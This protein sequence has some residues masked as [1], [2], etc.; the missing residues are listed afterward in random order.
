MSDFDDTYEDEGVVGAP[1]A[2]SFAGVPSDV[3]VP[4][5][6]DLNALDLYATLAAKANDDNIL[7]PTFKKAS[8]AKQKEIREKQFELLSPLLKGQD[9]HIRAAFSDAFLDKDPVMLDDAAPEVAQ[10]EDRLAR[11]RVGDPTAKQDFETNVITARM[12]KQSFVANVI[13]G[14]YDT[15]AEL[16]DPGKNESSYIAGAEQDKIQSYVIRHGVQEGL[17]TPKDVSKLQGRADF[18]GGAFAFT[19]TALAQVLLVGNIAKGGLFTK[20]AMNTVANR[21]AAMAPGLGRQVVAAVGEQAVQAGINAGLSALDT[22]VK[23]LVQQNDTDASLEGFMRRF[24]SDLATDWTTWA[25]IGAVGGTFKTLKYLLKGMKGSLTGDMFEAA[26]R[27]ADNIGSR[28]AAG[29]EIPPEVMKQFS[30]E[31]QEN[32]A[33]RQ[34]LARNAKASLAGADPTDEQLSLALCAGYASDVDATTGKVR[35]YEMDKLNPEDCIGEFRTPLEA[36]DWAAK[37]P[38]LKTANAP[39]DQA[40]KLAAETEAS[41]KVK[42]EDQ[43]RVPEDAFD[44]YHMGQ[45]LK[46]G[47]DGEYDPNQLKFVGQQLGGAYG[48]RKDWKVQDFDINIDVPGTE[49]V[50]MRLGADLALDQDLRIK[51][52]TYRS[53][54][55]QGA[56]DAKLAEF[57]AAIDSGVIPRFKVETPSQERMYLKMLKTYLPENEEARGA[58]GDAI[59]RVF[60]TAQDTNPLAHA[61]PSSVEHL[62]SMG[63]GDVPVS[64]KSDM[65]TGIKRFELWV[66]Q[67]DN[68]WRKEA[69]FGDLAQARNAAVEGLVNGGRV[70][71][72]A[73]NAGLA[74]ATG[75]QIKRGKDGMFSIVKHAKVGTSTEVID[76]GKS[77][78]EIFQKYP[79]LMTK[80]KLPSECGPSLR[81]IDPAS[82]ILSYEG[83]AVKGNAHAIFQD[84]SQYVDP[85]DKS[86]LKYKT[87]SISTVDG[88]LSRVTTDA[89]LDPISRT[90]KYIPF[91]GAVP[92]EFPTA[93]ALVDHLESG[94]RD[95]DE[96][97]LNAKIRGYSLYNDM[98]GNW[99][100]SDGETRERFSTLQALRDK[101]TSEPM[102][103]APELISDFDDETLKRL[104]GD[105]ARTRVSAETPR[106][107]RISSSPSKFVRLRD[108]MTN[109]LTSTPLMNYFAPARSYIETECDRLGDTT[110]LKIFDDM[111]GAFRVKNKFVHSAVPEVY[112]LWKGT[113]PSERVLMKPMLLMS[114]A[115]RVAYA[116]ENGIKY[117]SRMADTLNSTL[118]YMDTLTAYA[119]LGPTQEILR[120]GNTVNEAVE[121][122]RRLGKP[123]PNDLE[124]LMQASN[125]GPIPSFLHQYK[126]QLSVRSFL[127]D[128]NEDDPAMMLLHMTNR[129]ASLMYMKPLQEGF[130]QKYLSL[131]KAY[132]EGGPKA[133]S[134]SL[135]K[136]MRDTF[137]EM[138]GEKT[139]AGAA[140]NES[141]RK[142]TR[143]LAAKLAK[144][145]FFKDL[146]IDDY[147]KIDDLIGKLGGEFT[148]ASQAGR[149]WAIPRNLMQNMNLAAVTGNTRAFKAFQY[150]LDN[151]A[152]MDKL[153]AR[154]AIE[155]TMYDLG[156]E[157]LSS[158]QR[159]KKILMAP[160]EV[161]DN[162]TRATAIR[163]AEMVIED[164]RPRYLKGIT[165]AEQYIREVNGDLLEEGDKLKFLELSKL[166]TD[167]AADF[168]GMRYQSW[169]MYDYA[170]Y[171]QGTASRGTLGRLWGKLG[172]YP[173]WTL[174]LYRRVLSKGSMVDRISRMTRMATTSMAV[175][176]A[177][178]EAGI[179]YDG[180]LWTNA[181]GFSGGPFFQNSIDVLQMWGDSPEAKM[182]RSRLKSNLSRELWAPAAWGNY[183]KRA[184]SSAEQNNATEFFKAIMAMPTDPET[185]A[186]L[187]GK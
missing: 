139:T 61:N 149:I 12:V 26:S 141:T 8:Y 160:L 83:N 159:A 29:E 128:V 66:K 67:A 158:V 11:M 168:L 52:S 163:S 63:H 118:K 98:K 130:G 125:L 173:L 48:G 101:F 71:L 166:N 23:M 109:W 126:N 15:L 177:F 165:N 59:E 127:E 174:D 178:K 117:T 68:T 22:G 170:K 147:V 46:A 129:A 150:V 135:L 58:L 55:L 161:T 54:A 111:T 133:P 138:C 79:G 156:G 7:D 17:L 120:Y 64:L 80:L 65:A 72:D 142:A 5:G 184:I 112:S 45:F 69:M 153:Q 74:S 70:S 73:I 9:I 90:F 140:L 123:I 41:G 144:Q 51:D 21:A 136:Y 36:S 152:Y 182:A 78:S 32:L 47:E 75:V 4:Q 104:D 20:G 131:L 18:A 30:K 91:E 124:E 28:L 62:F 134:E 99:V 10:A 145:P 103:D 121:N 148:F 86:T 185:Q 179:P 85:F 84:L 143:G 49:G 40:G 1:P 77:L 34:K 87:V 42:Y 102:P 114:E 88:H 19:E 38:T 116:A 167:A 119:N 6:V 187:L 107:E 76:K 122:L 35:L 39:I 96:M 110:A 169:T 13:E 100:L 183:Y 106:G 56:V 176:W 60:I 2:P 105:I 146:G 3:Q 137:E 93:R 50:R 53:D 92:E 132:S 27:A 164:A 33:F 155:E 157:T 95:L 162:I 82:R 44:T 175:Y 180:F 181:F 113:K 151:P 115:E 94:A 81:V 172:V 16:W 25:A 24:G 14:A 37:H 31:A 171:A 108:K 186:M 89:Q 57:K 154:Q 97:R 43:F